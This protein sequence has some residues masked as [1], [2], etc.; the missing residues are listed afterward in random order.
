[1]RSDEARTACYENSLAGNI[2]HSSV[3]Q[4]TSAAESDNPRGH[5]NRDREI[6]NVFRH[7]RACADDDPPAY[8]TSRKDHRTDPDI[9]AGT[10]GYRA[11]QL[12]RRV[13]GSSAGMP[14]WADV[15]ILTPGPIAADSRSVRGA[16]IQKHL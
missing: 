15:K 1:M 14:V 8:A 3:F 9:R 4:R 16:G 11:R 13:A 10:D 5:T 12:I 2:R 7:D 6:R